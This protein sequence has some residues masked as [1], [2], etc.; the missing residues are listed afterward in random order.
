[1]KHDIDEANEIAKHLNQDI[2]FSFGLISEGVPDGV[3]TIKNPAYSLDRKAYKF[4][5]KVHNFM[6]EEVYIWD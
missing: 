6:T 3:S 2:Q 4:E 5:V 1:M